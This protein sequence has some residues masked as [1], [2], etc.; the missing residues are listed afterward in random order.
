MNIENNIINDQKIKDLLSKTREDEKAIREIL[1]KAKNLKGLSIEEVAQLSVINDSQLTDELFKTAE[2]IKDEIYG[3]RL[4]VFAPLYI[5]NLCANECT[6]CAFRAGNKT[7]NRKALNQKEISQE[8]EILINQGH[9]RL[10]LVAGESYP[11]EGF[12]YILNSIKT[13]YSTKTPKGNIRRINVNIAP[14]ELE[15]FKE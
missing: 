8:T 5:S 15:E 7:I 10:L 9:K 1:F 2:H 6:Y 3:K 4:V 11:E 12:D 13:I 14:L